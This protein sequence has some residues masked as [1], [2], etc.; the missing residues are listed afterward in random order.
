MNN[1]LSI[2]E[3]CSMRSELTEILIYKIFIIINCFSEACSRKRL[4]NNPQERIMLQFF[5]SNKTS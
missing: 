2:L 5:I 4:S 3:L 1:E